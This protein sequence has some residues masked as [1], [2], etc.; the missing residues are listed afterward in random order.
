MAHTTRTAA[1]A[2]AALPTMAGLLMMIGLLA[3]T[4]VVA[5][6]A[7]PGAGGGSAAPG[8][9]GPAPSSTAPSGTPPAAA[10]PPGGSPAPRR[11]VT[12]VL[13]AGVT[14]DVCGIGL[15]VTI[16]PPSASTGPGYQA[17][18]VGASTSDRPPMMSDDTGDTP[19]PGTIAP[20]RP[21]TVATVL[22]KAFMVI[23]VDLD[24]GRVTL[25]PLC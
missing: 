15:R 7:R 1:P 18:L 4:T 9:T 10:T 11:G 21:G 19:H 6:C 3:V 2:V 25:Q 24:L 5:A 23:S 17:F 12:F 20:A 22:G 8:P 13:S 14:K 16:V